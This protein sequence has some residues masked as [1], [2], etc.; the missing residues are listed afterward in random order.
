MAWDLRYHGQSH[1]LTVRGAERDELRE[2]FEALHE[3]RYGHRD[4]DGE[5][6]LVT[7]RVTGRLAGPAGRLRRAGGRGGRGS[8]RRRAA[9]G[10]ARRPRGLERFDRRHRHA[11]A[12]AAG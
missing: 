4:P 9:R 2:R 1:E 12:G 10:D 3:E 7:V 11:R 6:E 8:G 5:V